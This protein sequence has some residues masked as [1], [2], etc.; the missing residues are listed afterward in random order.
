MRPGNPEAT[1]GRPR[2][3][4]DD[5][6]AVTVEM[7]YAFPLI[8]TLILLLAQAT[9]WWHAVHVAQA[10]A[11]DALAVTRVQGGTVGDGQDE[12]QRVLDQL[13]KGPL[14]GV[15]VHVTRNAD[16]AQVRI[17][18]TASSVVPFLHLPV[19]VD[20]AGPVE[21]FRPAVGTSP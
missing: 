18:G 2:S 4:W 3:R 7:L 14:R 9:I 15:S 16:G 8:F 20:A 21:Q 10:T 19:S 11:A 12:A 1:F 13:G 5:R 17:T 6:G